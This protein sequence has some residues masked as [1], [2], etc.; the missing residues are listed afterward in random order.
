MEELINDNLWWI[1]PL[2]ITLLVL[3]G[4]SMVA[5]GIKDYRANRNPEADIERIRSG[6]TSE[7]AIVP[8]PFLTEEPTQV[9]TKWRQGNAPTQTLAQVRVHHGHPDE[10][11]TLDNEIVDEGEEEYVGRHRLPENLTAQEIAALF[12]QTRE[13]PLVRPTRTLSPRWREAVAV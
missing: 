3:L 8:S 13:F 4:G 7:H 12:T 1:L 6:F 2:G 9:L 10:D 11:W 5:M